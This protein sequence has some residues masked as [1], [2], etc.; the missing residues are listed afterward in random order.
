MAVC[1]KCLVE[2]AN[3]VAVLDKKLPPCFHVGFGL[4]NLVIELRERAFWR[5]EGHR[6]GYWL[7]FGSNFS[8]ALLTQ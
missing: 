3:A 7:C 1:K 6:V 2:L 5:R 8:D 4:L